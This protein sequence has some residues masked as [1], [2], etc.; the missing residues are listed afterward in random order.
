MFHAVG[1]ALRKG[2]GNKWFPPV[3]LPFAAF[4]VLLGQRHQMPAVLPGIQNNGALQSLPRGI[5]I[6]ATVLPARSTVSNRQPYAEI[7]HGAAAQV[8]VQILLDLPAQ[9]PVAQ[10]GIDQNI[11]QPAK[12][13][14]PVVPGNRCGLDHGRVRQPPGLRSGSGKRGLIRRQQRQEG[15]SQPGHLLLHVRLLY[16]ILRRRSTAGT[17]SAQKGGSKQK[18]ECL[19]GRHGAPRL[20]DYA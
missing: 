5:D 8:P 17:P 4:P 19:R 9:P 14:S 3:L 10:V 15:I 6:H 16:I 18:P 7:L 12:Q 20:A 2:L 13:H 11:V 1:M